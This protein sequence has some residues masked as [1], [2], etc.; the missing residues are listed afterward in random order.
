[1]AEQIYTN[2]LTTVARVKDRMSITGASWDTVFARLINSATDFIEKQSNRKFGSNSYIETQQVGV[3]GAK[4]IFLNQPHVTALTKIEY[5]Q[6]LY[7]NPN[8]TEVPTTDYELVEDGESGIIRIHGWAWKGT[9]TVRITYTAGYTIDFANAG[10]LTKHDLPADI[11]EL[12]EK[13]VVRWFKK[14]EAEGKSEEIIGAEGGG[15]IRWKDGLNK[16]DQMIID[17]YKK[18]PRLI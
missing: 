9:D 10:D 7:S 6:G 8:W 2:A 15:T 14:R 3:D 5:R 11:T 1:M 17:M 12:C 4:Y 18:P 13:L 16:D